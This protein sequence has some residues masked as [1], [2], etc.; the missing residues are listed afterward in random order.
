MTI[1]L[2]ELAHIKVKVKIEYLVK[3]GS[4]EKKKKIEN[5]TM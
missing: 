4:S 3:N 2:S 1:S 5:K